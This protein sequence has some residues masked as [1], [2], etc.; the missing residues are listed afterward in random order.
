MSILMPCADPCTPARPMAR[1]SRSTWSRRSS[2]SSGMQIKIQEHSCF[3]SML[4]IVKI[5][6]KVIP[7]THV[8]SKYKVDLAVWGHVHQYERSC[9]IASNGTCAKTDEDGTVHGLSR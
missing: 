4:I 2:L 3:F 7:N 5:I 1:S 9:G 6:L 8:R